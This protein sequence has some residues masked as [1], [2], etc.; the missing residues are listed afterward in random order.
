MRKDMLEFCGSAITIT[1]ALTLIA[2]A[3]PVSAAQAPYPNKPIRFVVPQ[4]P[5]GGSDVVARMLAQ[6]L[7]DN[8]H[9]QVVVDNRSGAGGIVG[10]EV[11][12]RSPADGYTWL[13]GYT[14][15][16]T[17]NPHLYKDLPYRPME[18]FDPVSLAVAS[19]FIL[20][21][22]PKINVA[23]VG[24]LIAQARAKPGT[25]NFGSPG[26]GSLGHLAMEWF[27]SSTGTNMVHVP[28]KGGG[29]S[30]SVLISG[31]IQMVL[32]SVV[33]WLPHAKAGRI[34]PIA[35]T[36]KARS[37]A[38]PDLPT[39]AESGVP[40]FEAGNWFGVLLPRGAPRSIV[41]KLS[42][43][44]AAEVNSAEFKTR[45]LNDGVDP[46]GSTP[47]AFAA[48]IRTELKR[49]GEVVKYSGAKAE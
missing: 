19:P 42:S 16:L 32:G 4:P 10:T 39:I 49:W 17:I 30:L 34:K 24:D 35:I 21:V 38:L 15:P 18:D 29:Q 7:Q 47:E 33:A 13:L 25:L 27:R 20:F 1:C 31:E 3:M 22:N 43:S 37:R 9:Q 8:L 45:L 2:G 48:V 23:T 41:E 46:V 26:N 5:G 14:G 28:F 36:S 44:I 11:A 40:N 12:A 6:K